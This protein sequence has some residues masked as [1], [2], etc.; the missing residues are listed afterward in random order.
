MA[1]T[2]PWNLLGL[3]V[4][5]DVAGYTTYT[6][7]RRRV[8][9]YPVAPPKD[10]PT[11]LQLAHRAR[12]TAAIDAWNAAPFSDRQ[13]WERMAKLL[14]LPMTGLNAWIWCAFE[15]DDGLAQTLAN[16]SQLALLFPPHV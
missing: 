7:K 5:G 2:I 3:D 16:Q 10:P 9:A 12:F 13:D 14:S 6:D 4:A 15:P 11:P 8:I 1:F